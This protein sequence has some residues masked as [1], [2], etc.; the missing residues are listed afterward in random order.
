MPRKLKVVNVAEPTI[1]QE[2]MLK[3][4]NEPT[5]AETASSPSKVNVDPE[6]LKIED[7]VQSED[8]VKVATNETE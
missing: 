8:E 5:P 6:P 4:P 7:V 2:F 1:K 3:I